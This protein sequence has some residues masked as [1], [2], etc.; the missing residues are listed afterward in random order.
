V[1]GAEEFLGWRHPGPWSTITGKDPISG[2]W[3]RTFAI[4]TTDV[5]E[6]L[7]EIHD[8]M[9]LILAPDDGRP[10]YTVSGKNGQAPPAVISRRSRDAATEPPYSAFS[11]KTTPVRG[12]T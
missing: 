1:A 9:P 5:N 3:I 12:F 4:I 8:R 6:M 7:A 11:P 2:E 10:A